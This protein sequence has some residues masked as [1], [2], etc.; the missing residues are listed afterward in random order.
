MPKKRVGAGHEGDDAAWKGREKTPAVEVY[1]VCGVQRCK[2]CKMTMYCS[3]S[4]Q[5]SHWDYHA[6][7]CD[8]IVELKKIETDKIYKEY[9]VRQK[10]VDFKTRNKVMKLVGNKPMLSCY[11]GEKPFEVLWD[12]GSMISL[13]DRGWVQENFPEEKIYSVSEFLEDSELRVQAANATTIKF[14]GVMLLKFSVDGGEGFDVPML[15]ASGEISEPI[16]GYNVIEHLVLNGTSEQCD[17]LQSSL[18]KGKVEMKPLVS[19]IQQKANNPDFLT[20][21]K[22]STTTRVPAGHRVQMKCRVKAQGNAE[23]Q[24]VYFLPRISENDQVTLSETVSTL[25]RGRTNYVYVDVINA[26]NR[27]QMVEKGVIMGSIHSVSAVM[28]MVKF[29]GADEDKVAMVG[30]LQDG[31]E[32]DRHGK[33]GISKEDAGGKGGA[34][35]DDAGQEVKWKLDHLDE[36]SKKMLEKVLW[37]ERE[38]FAKHECDIGS[39]PDFKMEINVVDKVPVTAAY[40]RIPPH[41]YKEVRDYI[42]DL[43]TNGWIRESFSSYSS[44]IVCVR[45]KDGGMRMCC[46]Y[47]QLNGKT[48]PD[49]QPIPRIQDILDSLGGKKWFSTLDMAKAYH[50]GYIAESSRHLTAFVTPWTLFEWVRIPFGLRNAPPAFQRYVNQILGDLKGVICEPYLDDILCFS[51][52]FKEHVMDLQQVLKRL[53]ARGVKLRADKCEFAKREVRY[54][55]RLISEQGYR[56]DPMDTQALDKFKSPPRTVGEL[57]S[58]L[59]FLGYYRCYVK[60][61]SRRIKPLY[62]LLTDKQC[63]K[64]IE[65]EGV[66]EKKKEKTKKPGQKYDG[67]QAIEWDEN[68]QMILETMIGYLKSP[69]VIAF[70]DFDLPFFLNCDASKEGLGAVL[71]QTQGGVDRVISYASRTLLEAEKNYHSG[72]LEFLALKWAITERF[73]DYLRYGPPFLVYT[74]NN[75]L[76]YVLTTAKLN[77]VG[78]RWVNDLADYNFTIKYRP[79]KE[80]ADAD[81]LSRRP[82]DIGELK[83]SC[84][85][86][87]HPSW[88]NAVVLGARVDRPVI[89]NAVSVEKMVLKPDS[90]VIPVS[91]EV[92]KIKQERDDIIAPVF[93]AVSNGCRPDRKE[94]L[95]MSRESRILM[96]SFKKLC[97]QDGV[98]MRQTRRYLQIVLPREFHQLVFIEL[99][100]KMAHLGVEK[101]TDL[102]QQRF[103]WPRMGADIKHYIQK[104]CRCIVNKKPN[105]QDRAPL[106]PVQATSPFQMVSIDYLHLDKCK[107]GYQYAMVVTDHF[108]RFCQVYATRNKSTKAAADKLFN[109]FIMQFGYPERIHHDQGPEFNSDLFKEL[110][111]LTGIKASNTTPYHP[112]GDGQCERLNRTIINMLKSLSDLAKRDWRSQLPKL[113]FAYNSTSNKT[114]GF[115]P[116]FLMFGRESRLPIDEIFQDVGESGK[117]RNGNHAKFVQEWQEA[118]KE[119][120]DVARKNIQKSAEWNKKYYDRKAKAVELVMG[121]MVLVKNT[122]ARGGTGKMRSFWEEAIFRIVEKK[123]NLPVYKIRNVAKENDVRVMHR[124]LL[125][126][127]NDLPLSTFEDKGDNSRAKKKLVTCKGKRGVSDRHVQIEEAEE[128]SDEDVV[129]VQEWSQSDSERDLVEEQDAVVINEEQHDDA[130]GEMEGQPSNVDDLLRTSNEIEIPY[131]EEEEGIGEVTENREREE[132]EVDGEEALPENVVSGVEDTSGEESDDSIPLR[133]SNRNCQKK[134]VFTYLTVGGDPV[135]T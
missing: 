51:K 102:A 49:A 70:P 24:T 2:K 109:E 33:V 68:H 112:M 35:N 65:K 50:Q 18:G 54:L 129:L 16:L 118:M 32:E 121:D 133:R 41:L 11:L 131:T 78:M 135:R 99:H 94:W 21:V 39:I 82:M 4:C 20:E 31:K 130:V 19:L 66:L 113:S 55:G 93:R 60:D 9:S 104:K 128:E 73:S 134:K 77:A 132:V 8:A 124:N 101:V 17:A 75:P 10:G 72:K 127:C 6:V 64:T 107:G 96:K 116:F 44:P 123:A 22:A 100:E 71:Y 103:Y 83:K 87:V 106:V 86:T 38:V 98:L 46:D 110:H 125:L 58:L 63:K 1:C 92:L 117:L 126:R 3:K 76:T 48:V 119:A 74:D 45:K 114:T 67:K 120:I 59:G 91:K 97:V 15:I 13:V 26:T 62:D 108:T 25:R 90:E 57:R 37:E 5:K 27:E 53:K 7:Y 29:G 42:N 23:E 40:R 52:T 28:P 14:D 105:V 30:C 47:R 84:G 95:E 43:V 12:T 80:N 61:F 89:S 122:R 85:E 88:V 36:R 79:G 34:A 111:R 56:P 115:S 69:E 81:L